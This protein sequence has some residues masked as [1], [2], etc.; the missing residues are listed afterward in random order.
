MELT[1]REV[2]KIASLYNKLVKISKY[3][4][5]SG[6]ELRSKVG[7]KV[8]ARENDYGEDE[9]YARNFDEPFADETHVRYKPKTLE[10]IEKE[11]KPKKQAKKTQKQEQVK[12]VVKGDTVKEKKLKK[13]ESGPSI[14]DEQPVI[15]ESSFEVKKLKAPGQLIDEKFKFLDGGPYRG[16]KD[17]VK[18]K[19][20]SMN[21]ERNEVDEEAKSFMEDMVQK[22]QKVLEKIEKLVETAPEETDDSQKIVDEYNRTKKAY[23]DYK[24]SIPRT[25]KDK[26]RLARLQELKNEFDKASEDY[27]PIKEMLENTTKFFRD[28]EDMGRKVTERTILGNE[29]LDIKKCQYGYLKKNFKSIIEEP[30]NRELS[31]RIINQAYKNLGVGTYVIGNKVFTEPYLK[32]ETTKNMKFIESGLPNIMK[33][34]DKIAEKEKDIFIEKILEKPSKIWVNFYDKD[35]YGRK[36]ETEGSIANLLASG[37]KNSGCVEGKS[38]EARYWKQ[39]KDAR[40]FEAISFIHENED[41]VRKELKSIKINIKLKDDIPWSDKV[42]LKHKIYNMSDKELK[43]IL[44]NKTIQEYIKNNVKSD[45]AEL[46]N[47]FVNRVT[48]KS[49]RAVF[50]FLIDMEDKDVLKIYGGGFWG[51]FAKGFKQGFMG[52]LGVAK[53]ILPFVL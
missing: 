1:D 34:I 29:L 52:T 11:Y 17:N 27:K 18:N 22:G 12:P 35:S 36:F 3:S 33:E 46:L 23:E 24:A 53:D 8:V 13:K 37:M 9:F 41:F 4:K 15:D 14:L 26:K 28:I 16:I 51:D 38:I 50:N 20:K 32:E 21:L 48:D 31:T 45:K 10:K 30:F 19:N 2:K 39:G 43:A 40:E 42:Y 49:R 7:E 44:K 5:L 25:S 47:Q 6:E